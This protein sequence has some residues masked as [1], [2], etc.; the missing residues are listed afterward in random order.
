[1]Q[2][3]ISATS[4]TTMSSR[5]IA[6]L[7][8]KRHDNVVRDIEKMFN[9]LDKDALKFEDIYFDSKNRKQKRYLLDKEM[10]LVLVSGYSIKLRQKIVARWM[11][12]E[13]KQ[14]KPVLGAANLS[15]LEILK[16]AMEAEEEKLHLAA[17]VEEMKPEVEALACI[18]KGDES[19]CITDA[20]KELQMRPKDLFGWLSMNRWIYRR[21]GNLSWTAYQDKQQQ[22]LLEHKVSSVERSDGTKKNVHQVRVTAK[23]LVKIATERAQEN[24]DT[25]DEAI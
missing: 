21:A 17:E 3:L 5:E 9:G 7:C 10:T 22:S 16:I 11:E 19:L 18:S 23:G 15:R 24:D 25:L 6:E 4:T 13:S 12:L 1:M 8:G 2:N 20:A 14:N